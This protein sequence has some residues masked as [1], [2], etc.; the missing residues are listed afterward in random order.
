MSDAGQQVRVDR[1]GNVYATPPGRDRAPP[2]V[3]IG[4]HIDTAAIGGAFDGTLGAFDGT[5]GYSAASR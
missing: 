2:C 1:I 3:L 5:R 4:S